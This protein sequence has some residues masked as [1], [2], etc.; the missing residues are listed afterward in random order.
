[1]LGI[2]RKGR[3]TTVETTVVP[4]CLG[5]IMDGNRR[6]A[7][8][9]GLPSFEGHRR[10]YAKLKKLTGWA[11]EAGVPY[12]IVYAFSTEN[13][14]RTKEEVEYLMGLFCVMM[15][16][17]LETAKAEKTR[18][19]FI[20]QRERFAEDLVEGMRNV[21]EKTQKYTRLT[22]G[23]ALSYGG[24]SEILSAV[25]SLAGTDLS[26]LNEEEFSKKLWTKDFPDPDMIIRTSGERRTSGFLTWQSVYSEL[27][28]TDTYWPAFSK[29]EFLSLLA[30]YALRK[31]RHGV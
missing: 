6:W 4:R 18:V 28:F 21:E 10:G 24:R 16:D 31:R 17:L 2:Q 7:K 26:L 22:L 15:G 9:H 20:G 13:W 12:L 30:E 19:I 11:K 8:S 23:V 14:N 29:K 27:F 3:T 1:M 25:R 5:I